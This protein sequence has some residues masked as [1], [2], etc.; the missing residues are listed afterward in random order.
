MQTETGT[1]MDLLRSAERMVEMVEDGS[2]DTIEK[3]RLIRQSVET[4]LMDVDGSTLMVFEREAAFF[5]QAIE[6]AKA[7]KEEASKKIKDAMGSLLDEQ[8]ADAL[9]EKELARSAN[10]SARDFLDQARSRIQEARKFAEI[11]DSIRSSLSG[12]IPTFVP[13]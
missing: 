8:T 2:V 4:G 6:S 11:A 12:K 10:R 1:V 5:A 7:S 9:E 3:V 13:R